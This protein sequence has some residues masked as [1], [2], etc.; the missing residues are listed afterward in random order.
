MRVRCLPY[1]IKASLV[2]AGLAV[3]V[4]CCPVHKRLWQQIAGSH[5][6][7]YRRLKEPTTLFQALSTAENSSSVIDWG[8]FDNDRSVGAS[9]LNPKP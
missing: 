8:V 7:V 5:L 9:S 6:A 1:Q 4:V 3:Q 2:L